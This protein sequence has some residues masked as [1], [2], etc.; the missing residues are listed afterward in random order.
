MDRT[1]RR[2]LSHIDSFDIAYERTA[3]GSKLRRFFVDLVCWSSASG[4]WILRNRKWF[5]SEMILDILVVERDRRFAFN[6][7]NPLKDMSNYD[8]DDSTKGGAD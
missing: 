7:V 3:R 4:Q 2:N 6:D 1:S 5:P 8:A